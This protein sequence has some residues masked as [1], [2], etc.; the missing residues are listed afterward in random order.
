MNFVRGQLHKEIVTYL[1]ET[2]EL[3][4]KKEVEEM[5]KNRKTRIKRTA[6]YGSGTFVVEGKK[7]SQGGAGAQNRR[8]QEALDRMRRQRGGRRGNAAPTQQTAQPKL[9]S[10]EGW[11]QGANSSQR[12]FFL[13]AYYA[14]KSGHMEV[15]STSWRVC[16]E[17]GG[18]G[19]IKK[20]GA[21]GGLVKVTCPRSHGLKGDKMIYYR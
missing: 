16:P 19:T 4:P 20:L 11:W 3:D 15:I 8:V 17:C 5:W 21:Q 12:S 9:V 7:G 18:T 14:E 6:T 13:R 10:K 1:A 2:H